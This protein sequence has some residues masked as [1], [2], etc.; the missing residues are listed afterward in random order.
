[1]KYVGCQYNSNLKPYKN[2]DARGKNCDDAQICFSAKFSFSQ[3]P[4]NIYYKKYVYLFVIQRR[5]YIC[6]MCFNKYCKVTFPDL[7]CNMVK[8]YR[9]P[10]HK[11]YSFKNLDEG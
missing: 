6:K 11:N 10:I 4:A 9:N 7:L 1:M 3:D 5:L 8:K 2:D